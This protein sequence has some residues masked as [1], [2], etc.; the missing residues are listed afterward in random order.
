MVTVQENLNEK[1]E[2]KRNVAVK[3]SNEEFSKLVIK[4]LASTTAGRN[5]VKN[6]KQSEVRD[7]I[8][9]YKREES[10][11]KLLSIS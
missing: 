4:D 5:V 7:F 10:Q 11:R 9:N 2:L 3:F 1:E 6:F 8:N